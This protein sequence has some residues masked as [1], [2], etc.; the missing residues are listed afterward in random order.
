MSEE[1]YLIDC[2]N[3]K[4]QNYAKLN[5]R[6]KQN[7]RWTNLVDI[8]LNQGD[9]I[10][11]QDAILNL[12]GI[13]SDATVEILNENNEYG[14][15]DSK[16]GL[17]FVPYLTDMGRNTV[18]LP[19][20]GSN[21]AWTYSTYYGYIYEGDDGDVPEG[22]PYPDDYYPRLE[23]FVA[24]Y[25]YENPIDTNSPYLFYTPKWVPMVTYQYNQNDIT[26]PYNPMEPSTNSDQFKFEYG[27][28]YTQDGPSVMSNP[29]ND[30]LKTNFNENAYNG[31]WNYASGYK[32]ILLDEN[33]KGPFRKNNT[34]GFWSG[35]DD[36]KPQYMDV[37]IDVNG[38]IYESPSTISNIINEQLNNS[39]PYGVN[40]LN[41]EFL[42]DYS[43]NEKL[44]SV[45]GNLLRN[46]KC[47]GYQSVGYNYNSDPYKGRGKLWG[48]IAVRDINKWMG[49]HA[50]MRTDIAFNYQINYNSDSDLKQYFIYHP[51]FIMPGS[52]MTIN[53]LHVGTNQKRAFYP[54]VRKYMTCDSAVIGSRDIT[55]EAEN[56]Y[57]YACLPQYFLMCTNMKYNEDNIK[58]IHKYLTLNEKYDG[59]YTTNENSDIENWRCPF[60]IGISRQGVADAETYDSAD[61]FRNGHGSNNF[62]GATNI[63]PS[64]TTAYAHSF[65]YYPFPDAIDDFSFSNMP[66]TRSD[67]PDIGSSYMSLEEETTDTGFI[68][69]NIYTIREFKLE[70]G[71]SN[72]LDVPHRFKNNKEHDASINFYSKYNSNWKNLYRT[73]NFNGNSISSGHEGQGTYNTNHI[74]VDDVDDSLSEQY[75]VGVYPVSIQAKPNELYTYDLTKTY[76]QG[77]TYFNSIEPYNSSSYKITKGTG[78][79]LAFGGYDFYIW[80]SG[81]NYWEKINNL[82]IYSETNNNVYTGRDSL[83]GLQYDANE[84]DEYNETQDL[85]DINVIQNGNQ[86]VLDMG[87]DRRFALIF[88][89]T[90]NSEIKIYHCTNFGEDK[91]YYPFGTSSHDGFYDPITQ[92]NIS[93]TTGKYKYVPSLEEKTNG[94]DSVNNLNPTKIHTSNPFETVCAFLLYRDSATQKNDGSWEISTDF[95]LPNLHHAIFTASPSFFDNPAVWLTCASR[96]DGKNYVYDVKNNVFM[97]EQDNINYLSV[98]ANNPSFQFDESISRCTFTNL[99]NP[100]KLAPFDMPISSDSTSIVTSTL[101]D[102]VIKV[103]D[104]KVKNSYFWEMIRHRETKLE[105]PWEEGLKFSGITGQ[106]PRAFGLNYSTGGV[107]IWSAFGESAFKQSYDF[108]DLIEFTSDNWTGSLFYKL[109]FNYTDLFP[110]FGLQ[111]NYYDYSKVNNPDPSLR[112]EL[113]KPLTTNPLIDISVG[114]SLPL[115]DHTLINEVSGVKYSLGA[116]DPNYTVSVGSLQPVNIDGSTSESIIASDLPEKQNSSYFTIYSDFGFTGNYIQ[117]DDKLQVIGIIKKNYISGDFVY[118]QANVPFTVPITQKVTSINVE[119]RN[120]SGRL[121]SLDDNNSVIFLLRKAQQ[122][123]I[124]DSEKDKEK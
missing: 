36:C 122:Q 35:E 39:N 79:Q 55:V 57:H 44:P 105:P 82:F 40:D 32:Y 42:S 18:A 66:T 97:K 12:K 90:S 25:K 4:S 41:P 96:H 28:P 74:K 54:R 10:N 78:D 73:D 48:Q 87:N 116:G 46:R 72:K 101:G 70:S 1:T 51:L 123:I 113:L 11:V 83:Q 16:I 8:Q 9:Q 26:A 6:S 80:K 50:L 76:W 33:Y 38:P 112:Y 88:N 92:I 64:N 111:Q 107:F 85:V 91:S 2:S 37:K 109:G 93:E 61:L 84:Y 53:D 121:V 17:R 47:N 49:I 102:I 22:F 3:I 106:K 62:I 60:D 23:G 75:N 117:N 68:T 29:F 119:I 67:I 89:E 124:Q 99:H 24:G 95:A 13:S 81:A 98:G 7:A 63:S 69:K 104:N 21:S 110:K 59:K 86:F 30:N 94:E 43:I 14:L 58:R 108:N 20:V 19:Y 15:S 52:H 114:N 118:G 5:T 120:N 31:S 115:Q 34:G 27:D 77:T 71:T 100:K 103:N 56:N 45:T 65:P